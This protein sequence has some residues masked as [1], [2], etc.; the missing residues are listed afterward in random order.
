MGG[1]INKKILSEIHLI[2]GEVV[3]PKPFKIDREKLAKDI[4]KSNVTDSEL[5]FSKNW[6][7]LNTYIRDHINA[8]FRIS[9]V[10]KQAWGNTYK[11]NEI[12]IPLLNVNPMDY[13]NSP[14]YTCLY[15]VYVN[16]CMVRIHYDDNKRKGNS[17]DIPLYNNRFVI[18]PSTCMYYLKNN[19]KK[20]LNFVQTITYEY[21]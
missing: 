5:P 19:Q 9:L 20:N 16:N 17:W 7:M 2:Y 6:D 4:L 15:G 18:F 1:G 10:N 14:D 21:T 8:E 11:S 12:T 3:M 13:A